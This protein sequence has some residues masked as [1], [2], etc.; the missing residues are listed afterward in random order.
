[1]YLIWQEL[2]IYDNYAKLKQNWKN[3]YGTMVMTQIKG[4][5]NKPNPLKP[6]ATAVYTLLPS[7]IHFAVSYFHSSHKTHLKQKL[8][9]PLLYLWPQALG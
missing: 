2:Q 8:F 1:M 3:D 4:K 7:F 6:Y 9:L 5:K